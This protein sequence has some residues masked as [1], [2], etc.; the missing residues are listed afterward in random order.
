MAQRAAPTALGKNFNAR[1]NWTTDSYDY[2]GTPD[3]ENPIM[4]QKRDVS[5]EF[6][7]ICL[8]AILFVY[9][10]TLCIELDRRQSVAVFISPWMYFLIGIC[11]P[12]WLLVCSLALLNRWIHRNHAAIWLLLVPS[13][14]LIIGFTQ[15][16]LQFRSMS[17]E[18]LTDGCETPS[19]AHLEQAFASAQTVMNDCSSVLSNMTGAAAT[20]TRSM[21]RIKDCAGYQQGQATY[22]AEWRYF[23]YMERTYH[24]GGWCEP[25]WPIWYP[26]SSVQ[27]GCSL[28]AGR[29][30]GGVAERMSKQVLVYSSVLAVVVISALFLTPGLVGAK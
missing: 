19:K 21:I 3:E 23:E 14:G 18:L 28:V 30:L 26:A 15:Q 12:V 1:E 5:F 10:I 11:I 2:D 16:H 6:K 8:A 29:V 22:Q 25:R 13:I 4:K 7:I 9:P 17:A 20:E 27:D 24:C